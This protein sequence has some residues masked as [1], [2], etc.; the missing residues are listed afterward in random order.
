MIQ[1]KTHYDHIVT[2]CGE[3][4]LKSIVKWLNRISLREPGLLD[5]WKFFKAVW[6]RGRLKT[7]N[8]RHLM[9]LIRQPPT[10][11]MGQS[12]LGNGEIKNQYYQSIR[13]PP[14]VLHAPLGQGV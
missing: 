1:S 3:V 6:H 12:W 11:V 5:Y 7:T 14:P 2:A 8:C 4:Y 13:L 9:D 10:E